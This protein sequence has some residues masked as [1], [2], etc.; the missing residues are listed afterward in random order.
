MTKINK[1]DPDP[2]GTRRQGNIPIPEHVCDGASC[3]CQ[4][5]PFPNPEHKKP[6]WED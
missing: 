2:D 5:G 3:W 1:G 6:D 4:Q